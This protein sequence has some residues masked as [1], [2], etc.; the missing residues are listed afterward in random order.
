MLRLDQWGNSCWP[1]LG[2]LHYRKP[3]RLVAY[4]IYEAEPQAKGRLVGTV[5]ACLP[6]GRVVA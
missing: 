4:Q 5:I 1:L 3:A 6:C 2:T